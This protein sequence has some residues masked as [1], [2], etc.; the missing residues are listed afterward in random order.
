MEQEKGYNHALGGGAKGIAE[1]LMH[2]VAK[3]G[4]KQHTSWHGLFS[5][6]VL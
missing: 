4:A 1:G 5:L 2:C 3:A 6:I